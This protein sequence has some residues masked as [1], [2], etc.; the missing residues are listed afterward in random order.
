MRASVLIVNYNGGRH[1]AACL[2]ALDAQTQPRDSF[3]V[4]VVDNASTDDSLAGLD[5]LHPHVSFIRH[6]VNAGFAE[7]NNIAA[8]HATA[9]IIVLLNNDTRPDPFWLEELLHVMEEHDCAAAVSKL[10]FADDPTLLNSGGLMLLRDGRGADL[11]LRERD[12]GQFE[13]VRPVFAGCGAAFALRKPA[14]DVLDASLFLYYEDLDLAWR[15]QLAGKTV[16]YAPRSL[17]LHAV[18]ASAGAGSPV[19]RFHVERNRALVAGRYGDPELAVYAFLV[20]TLKVPQALL[21]VVTGR[22]SVRQALAVP[23]A[24]TSYLCR[25]PQTLVLRYLAR[26]WTIH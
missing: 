17:V 2:A 1:L 8:R 13:S 20:L 9:P 6:P 21:C 14:G 4:I 7:G 22:F 10:V 16:L 26:S 18:G 19:Q 3:Q 5:E 24:W 15:L 12:V 25:L 11:G 23:R